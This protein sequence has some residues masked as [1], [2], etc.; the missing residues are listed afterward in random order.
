MDSETKITV[1]DL[2]MKYRLT[3]SLAAGL[4]LLLNNQAVTLDD[5]LAVTSDG[6]VL[7]H[8]LRKRMPSLTIRT[9]RTLGYWLEP[10]EK[11]RIQKDILGGEQL[12][13]PLGHGVD[14]AKQPGGD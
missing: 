1:V 11:A 9:R 8:R 13:I 2:Q 3:K 12:E 5:L 7:I 10:E 4:H 14:A 6:K